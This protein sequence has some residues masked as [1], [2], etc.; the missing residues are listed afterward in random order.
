MHVSENSMWRVDIVEKNLETKQDLIILK[1][2]SGM[3]AAGRTA[4]QTRGGGQCHA[5]SSEWPPHQFYEN[6]LLF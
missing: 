5:A 2:I 1:G 4:D 6:T 3:L